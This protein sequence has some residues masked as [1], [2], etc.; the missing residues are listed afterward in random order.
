MLFFIFLGVF[1][2]ENQSASNAF[3]GTEKVGQLLK[4]FAI[5]CVLSL[6]IQALYNIVDQIFI[7]QSG[8]LPLGNTATGIVYPLTVI[9]LALGLFIGDGTAAVISI[10]Q[11]KN[12]T[13]ST[14]KAVGTGI[15]FGLFAGIL[16]TAISFAFT[17]PILKF[18]GAS[19]SGEIILPDAKEYSVFIFS[20]FVFFI[21]ACVINP[22][23]RADGSPKYAMLAMASGAVI[24]IILDPVLL[25]SAHMGMNGAALA[26]F[27]GQAA[28]FAMHILYL[29]K[30]RNFKLGLQSFIPNFKILFTSLKLGVSS[31]LTQF[32]IVV[33]SVLNNNL[34]VQYFP[35]AENAIGIFTVAFKVFGIV[36]SIAVG[37]ASGGQ[38]IL[39]YN[40]GARKYDR[41]KAAF[42]LIL[43]WTA[44][45]GIVATIL[46]ESCPSVFLEMFGYTRSGCSD[47]EYALGIN[48]F[49]I[50]IGFIFL[51]CIIKVVSIFFQAI[52][53][54]VKAMLI[55]LFRDVIFVVPLACLLPLASK[56]AFF[57]SAPIS[58]VLTFAT[59]CAMLIKVFRQI[60][61]DGCKAETPNETAVLPSR[62]GV[63]VT[64][65]R[66]HGAG[67]ME[68]GKKL[69]AKMGV[70]F[71]DKELTSLVAKESGLDREF[72][73]LI[74]EKTS[75]LY[76]LYLSTEANK[77]AVAAQD[78][79]L[80]KIAEN[81]SCVVV[82]RAADYVLEKYK[83]YKVFIYAPLE[84]RKE[85][86]MKNYGDGEQTAAANIER[87]DR[88]RAKFYGN[89][90]GK[91]W[92][93]K[94]NYNLL[95]DSSLGI[96]KAVEQILIGIG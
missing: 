94:N 76:S 83:P 18:F 89:V 60:S 79:V 45:V 78:K 13:S 11:G 66:E 33:I 48:A 36:I 9:A 50:Y 4:K 22:I 49:R 67:G 20:G 73:D 42:K 46:F 7:G 8:Y 34:L 62:Q 80:K 52:G 88:R 55:A 41:V 16:L 54:P 93:D 64:I 24:N 2:E 87:A 10:N 70:P 15:T 58:D 35:E 95:I 92:G 12:D 81:G 63:I 17:E 44:V 25:Y 68:I 38:P 30:P 31:F 91:I 85:R 84:Y 71:Y 86:I 23:I 6:I 21:L 19:G 47:A 69:A 57:W 28:T 61:S 40:Y 74:E 32:S 82:G 14:H 51:T 27:I 90:S 37:I 77:T 43:I 96:D 29:F 75:V 1:M 72:V 53:M 39:G 5:P 26:T 56:D 65:S 59:A 3:L